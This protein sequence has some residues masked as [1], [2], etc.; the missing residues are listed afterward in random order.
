VAALPHERQ[1]CAGDAV[2]S[3]SLEAGP[4]ASRSRSPASSPRARRA[5][6]DRRSRRN[7]PSARARYRH[8]AVSS[9]PTARGS[10]RRAPGS[11]TGATRSGCVPFQ[12]CSYVGCCSVMGGASASEPMRQA[13]PRRCVSRRLPTARMPLGSAGGRADVRGMG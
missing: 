3:G 11:R 9:A 8:A 13:S 7:R 10:P 6:R 12:R 4:S 2:R 5:S 1:R